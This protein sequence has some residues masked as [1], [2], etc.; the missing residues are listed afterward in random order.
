MLIK[1]GARN[2]FEANPHDTFL[3]IG[4]SVHSP[5]VW[6]VAKHNERNI[7]GKMLEI[8]RGKLTE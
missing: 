7:T 3:G 6:D 4:V 5:V 8:I 2:I 1:T